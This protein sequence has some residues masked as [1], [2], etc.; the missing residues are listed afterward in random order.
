MADPAPSEE[1]A[2]LADKAATSDASSASANVDGGAFANTRKHVAEQQADGTAVERFANTK[3]NIALINDPKNGPR[4]T[5]T[6]REAGLAEDGGDKASESSEKS[7]ETAETDAASV[8]AD[9]PSSP[10]AAKP[11][12]TSDAADVSQSEAATPETA[13]G[14]HTAEPT[15]TEEKPDKVQ[16]DST[17]IFVGHNGTFY[18]ESWRWMDWRGTRQS[19]NWPAA[20]SFGQWFAYRRLHGYAGLYILWLAALVACAIN[21]VPILALAA[22]ALLGVGLSGVYGNTLYFQA[23][24]R[25]VDRVTKTG[26]GS[27][28]ERQGQLAAAGGTSLLALGIMTAMTIT[29]IAAVFAVTHSQRGGFFLNFWPF[30]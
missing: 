16:I 5:M 2:P 30:S 19:W 12:E 22:L 8:T 1:S 3:L 23:F 24:R 26:K 20:L 29:G 17:K 18:D 4:F 6:K 14:P 21:N 13:A 11:E 25:A 27:Y 10:A 7:E 9:R 28:E 15:T